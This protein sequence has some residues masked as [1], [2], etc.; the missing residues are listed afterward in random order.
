MGKLLGI[1]LRF[2]FAWIDAIVVKLI[3]V[4]Y[5]LL[6]DLSELVLYS[7][8]I[9]KLIGRRIGLILGIFMLFKL[10]VSL[11]NYM[12]SPDKLSDKTKGGGRLIINIVVSLALLISINFIFKEAYK[13]QGI[14]VNSHI[15]EKIFFGEKGMIYC[16]IFVKQ[17]KTRKSLEVSGFLEDSR[18][19]F[20]RITAGTAQASSL[21]PSAPGTCQAAWLWRDCHAGNSATPALRP[22]SVPWRPFPAAWPDP[23]AAHRPQRAQT[24]SMHG[25]GWRSSASPLCQRPPQD[26]LFSLARADRTYSVNH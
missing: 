10:A 11:I 8:S 25:S 13:V 1:I 18:Q 12:I 19:T 5:R 21:W 17:A 26:P 7:D 23:R 9:I 6:S 15:I 16:C 2:V 20:Q 14:I 24:I 4:L 22:G 3:T